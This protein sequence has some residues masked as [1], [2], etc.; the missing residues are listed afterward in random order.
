MVI[1]A[2]RNEC[3]AGAQPLLQLEAEHAAIETERAV[4]IGHLQVH[5]PNP[6]AGNDGGF[7]GMLFLQASV[8]RPLPARPGFQLS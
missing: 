3:R 7:S 1:A 4:E 6:R 2:S 5:M 8:P